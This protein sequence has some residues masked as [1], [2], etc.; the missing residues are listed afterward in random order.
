MLNISF[1]TAAFVSISW[2]IYSS[3]Y[4]NIS[5]LITN[6]NIEQLYQSTIIILLPIIVIWGVFAIIRNHYTDKRVSKYIY[7]LL[8][9]VNKNSTTAIN[10][11][12]ALSETENKLKNGF[13]LQEFN[14]LIS[15]IN[16]I[17]S[18]IIKRSNSASSTQ[19]EHLWARTSGG[20][21]WLMAKTFIEITNY[22]TGFIDH[23]KQ[24]AY[25]DN[26]LRGSI[27]EFHA[28]YKALQNLLTAQDTQKIFYNMI[29]Y[30]ALGKVF[31]I[32]T[33]IVEMLISSKKEPQIETLKVEK[34]PDNFSLTEESFSIPSFLSQSEPA[35]STREQESLEPLPPVQKDDE[36]IESGLRA[37]REEIL[38]PQKKEPEPI[39]SPNI[40]SFNQTQMAIN[41]IKRSP[42]VPP[43]SDT[44]KR[45]AP[46]ISLDEIE[47]EINA[48]PENNFDDMAYPFGAWTNGKNNK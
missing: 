45:Q 15:D 19:L 22:Q 9:Q 26:L 11:S 13:M 21:R 31:D 46:V 8:E 27:L 44:K 34:E 5:N 3:R 10:L 6:T 7:N 20:E 37:I 43:T 48:S 12:N 42:L 28:R 14:L 30:G 16:E 18:D 29:E 36:S 2:L 1:F 39:I 33:P 32:L 35:F 25:K 47:R 24:K 41:N 40:S 4:L 17:L 23:L 38:S